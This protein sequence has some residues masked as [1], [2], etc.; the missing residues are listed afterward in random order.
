MDT[1]TTPRPVYST[2]DFRKYPTE[3]VR[4]SGGKLIAMTLCEELVEGRWEA[5]YSVS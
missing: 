5:F 1:N 4:D 3:V 2:P